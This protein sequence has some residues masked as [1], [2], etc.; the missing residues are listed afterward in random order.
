VKAQLISLSSFQSKMDTQVI[1]QVKAHCENY[2]QHKL[3]NW[4]LNKRISTVDNFTNVKLVLLVG[5]LVLFFMFLIQHCFICRPSD[6]T[7]SEDAAIKYR[8][9]ATLALV[10]SDALT[11]RL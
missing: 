5:F 10:Q 6:F 3:S 11:T 4:A 1:L 2:K 7:K 9:V 8:P